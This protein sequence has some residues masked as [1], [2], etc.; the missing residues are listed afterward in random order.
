MKLNKRARGVACTAAHFFNKFSNPSSPLNFLFCSAR[1]SFSSLSLSLSLAQITIANCDTG[2][3][4]A[5]IAFGAPE[6]K[7]ITEA[8]NEAFK[9]YS[10]N[11]EW[12][13]NK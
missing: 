3:E 5:M 2:D 11:T 1:S 8:Q 12:S 4:D 13:P 10:Y 9:G 6:P 7:K